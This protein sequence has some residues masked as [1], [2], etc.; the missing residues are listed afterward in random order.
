MKMLKGALLVAA[1]VLAGPAL[2]QV[3]APVVTPAP[4]ANWSGPYVGLNVG[5]AM[6]THAINVPGGT[7]DLEGGGVVA[8]VHGGVNYML[9]PNWL[10]GFEADVQWTNMGVGLGAGGL[11]AN[12]QLDYFATLRGRLGVADGSW[13]WYGTGGLALAGGSIKGLGANFSGDHVGWTIGGGIEAK[14]NRQWTMGAEYLYARFD[15]SDYGT[16]LPISIEPE[17]HLFRTKLSRT[18]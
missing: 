16:G 8:G 18:F 3:K 12:I 1:L 7:L 5:G 14:I 15:G 10:V 11:N 13:L 2:A 9:S 6:S 17:M 4:V